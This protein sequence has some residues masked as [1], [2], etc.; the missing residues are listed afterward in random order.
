M[1]AGK[2]KL[3]YW[4]IRGLA[5]P[6]R[7]LLRY[8][9]ADWED[10]LYSCGD[11]PDFDKSCWF[12]NKFSLGLDFPNLPYLIDG[13]VK[14][15]QTF[16]IMRYIAEKF[17]MTPATAE[18]K[19]RSDLIEQFGNDFNMMHVRLSYSPMEAFNKNKAG[20]VEKAQFMLQQ[21]SDFLADRPF[22]AGSNI[23][24]A[25]FYIYEALDRFNCLS[26]G[27]VTQAN[28]QGY[29]KRFEAL[30]TLQSYFNSDAFKNRMPLNNKMASF[31]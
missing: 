28:M 11:G 16:C 31:K 26:P 19:Y 29:I 22:F 13:D 10:V 17:G 20:V 2:I 23:T 12:D 9:E 27:F 21:M 14:L 7:L 8:V 18:E 5:E 1:A 4:D 15:T 3:G 24:A 6:I 30:P 25:D